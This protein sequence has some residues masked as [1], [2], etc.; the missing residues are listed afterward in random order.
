MRHLNPQTWKAL[1]EF[2]P[3][4]RHGCQRRPHALTGFCSTATAACPGR[5]PPCTCLLCKLML[6]QQI[7][8]PLALLDPPAESRTYL[9][10]N[11]R[12]RDEPGEPRRL[13][14]G[15]S[16]VKLARLGRIKIHSNCNFSI[17]REK[18]WRRLGVWGPRLLT[19]EK[20]RITNQNARSG[21]DL[22]SVSLRLATYK[23]RL[24]LIWPPP[25]WKCSAGNVMQ[26]TIVADQ[27]HAVPF[28]SA[29]RLSA[30]FN[31]HPPPLP[32]SSP[33]PVSA[34]WIIDRPV[35]PQLAA[36]LSLFQPE[37]TGGVEGGS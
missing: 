32:P 35:T 26:P 9:L 22:C 34:C 31:P 29:L 11:C 25:F 19:I 27:R 4:V 18:T 28:V 36:R 6:S 5:A 13:M 3:A 24:Q 10:T 23:N 14:S 15:E 8:S 33:P 2:F 20:V 16:A 7:P 1:C 17:A 12:V 37:K 21:F 30:G